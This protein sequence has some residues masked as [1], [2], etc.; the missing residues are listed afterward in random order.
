MEK[1]DHE[2]CLRCG[3]KLKNPQARE[4]GYGAICYKKMKTECAR[5]LFAAPSICLYA[6]K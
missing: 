5:K 1:K 3:K 2:Y 6:E 4:I